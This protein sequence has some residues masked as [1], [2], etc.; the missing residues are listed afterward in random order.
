MLMQMQVAKDEINVPTAL[1]AF[2]DK[3]QMRR[4]YAVYI[5]TTELQWITLISGK[6][7]RV[8]N[9]RSTQTWV[10]TAL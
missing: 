1:S 7:S 8:D 10:Q 5:L 4:G 3:M 6:H 9:K 2:R